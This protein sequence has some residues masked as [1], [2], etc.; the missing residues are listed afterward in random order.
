MD[1]FDCYH[2]NHWKL[3]PLSKHTVVMC[4]IRFGISTI[5]ILLVPTKK[6]PVSCHTTNKASFK[7]FEHSIQGSTKHQTSS[8]MLH[9][10]LRYS[11]KWNESKPICSELQS[12]DL[13]FT[14]RF[15]RKWPKMVENFAFFIKWFRSHFALIFAI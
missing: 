9:F 8:S 7:S 5:S 12:S 11:C 1:L 14:Y 15:P 13:V 3:C 4:T 10:P 2:Q 6:L